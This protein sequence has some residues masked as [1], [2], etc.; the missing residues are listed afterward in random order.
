M[1]KP[2]TFKLNCR[3]CGYKWNAR[4]EFPKSCPDCKNRR[5]YRERRAIPDSQLD[6][7]AKVR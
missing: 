4:L 3:R 6:R 1:I 5:W 2:K 7:L